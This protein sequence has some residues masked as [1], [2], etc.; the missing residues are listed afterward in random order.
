MLLEPSLF[1]CMHP[2]SVTSTVR[3]LTEIFLLVSMMW[4]APMPVGHRHSEYSPVASLQHLDQHLR[5]FH[6]GFSNSEN[7]PDDWHW[8]WVY[9]ADNC[10]NLD[11]DD[12]HSRAER[13][14]LGRDIDLPTMPSV[15]RLERLALKQILARPPIPFDRQ[16]SFQSAVLLRSGLS[17]PELLGVV[18]C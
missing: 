1:A 9:P 17:L 13:Q 3:R 8:H 7:W 6:G 2:K 10:A 18:R 15:S 12:V 5:C 4:P 11:V 16:H 14:I